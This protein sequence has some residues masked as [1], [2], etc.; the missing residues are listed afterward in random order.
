MKSLCVIPARGGSKRIPHKNIK[1]FLGKPLIAYSIEAAINSGVFDEII[2]STDD[3]A[4]AKVAREFGAKTPFMREPKLS[5]DYATTSAVI[6]DACMKMG[7]EFK[8]ICCLYATAPL[9]TGEILKQAHTKFIGEN[10]EFLFSACEFSFPIQRAIKLDENGRVSMFYPQHLKT[11]SQ[12]LERAYHDA[13]QFYFGR[14][15]AWLEDKAIFAP[16]SQAFVLERNL[17]C[18]IDTMD[19]FE[20]AKKLYKI[21]YV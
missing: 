18:D 15:E 9:L 10:P 20:F 19:D 7:E 2:V 21:N 6:K 3:E 16:H 12:D 8:C 1:V 17:V 5:D 4:I 14:R 11:R 13:G